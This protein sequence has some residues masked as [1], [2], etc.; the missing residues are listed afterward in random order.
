M[1]AGGTGL[2]DFF[3]LFFIEKS[4]GNAYLDIGLSAN[5]T[6]AFT[7]L[8]NFFVRETFPGSNDRIAKNALFIVVTCTLEQR[9][10]I[11]KR[12]RILTGSMVMGTLRTVFAILRA[13]TTFS[14][15]DRTNVKSISVKMFTD[16]IGC[17]CELIQRCIHQS[18]CF[19]SGDDCVGKYFFFELLYRVHK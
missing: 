15:D 19:F 12:I 16:F 3:E 8:V 11:K 14:I 9:F 5:F 7:D 6:N 10:C 17:L 1:Y 4:K 18:E 13:T 2:F